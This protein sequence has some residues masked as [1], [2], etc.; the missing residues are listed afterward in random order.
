MTPILELD[1]IIF[2]LNRNLKETM[3]NDAPKSLGEHASFQDYVLKQLPG[4]NFGFLGTDGEGY[5]HSF[6]SSMSHVGL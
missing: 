1:E 2:E 3:V 4:H 5:H 6:Q